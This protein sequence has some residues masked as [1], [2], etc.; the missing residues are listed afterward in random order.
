L[1]ELVLGLA[2]SHSP[3]LTFGAELW[4]ARAADDF[5]NQQ[6]TL[7][8]G[9][10]LSYGDLLAERGGKYEENAKPDRFAECERLAG[11]QL[12]RLA[13]ELEAAAPDLVIIIGDD[14]GELFDPESM[15]AIAVYHGDVV[16][17]HP[18]AKVRPSIP[19]W[20]KA[21]A[22]VFMMDE[23]HHLPGASAYAYRLI[24]RLI[25]E[26]V[27]LAAIGRVSEP[28]RA[29]FGHAY[30]FVVRRLFG[31]RRIPI[32]PVMLNTYF[33]PNVLSAARCFDIGRLM[34]AAIRS[35]P[36]ALRVAVI[37]SG[38]LSHFVTDEKL[39]RGVLGALSKGNGEDLRTLPRAA[40]RSGS[41]EILNWVVAAGA[42]NN[43]PLVW[44][45]YIPVYRTPAGTGIGL[46]FACWRPK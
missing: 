20:R 9:R 29:G 46:G 28:E 24:Q 5:G 1:S 23:A 34:G 42:L 33:P 36:D 8:D 3:L 7:S 6:L 16:V 35:S 10:T 40:L 32:V 43:L 26:G 13:K 31:E 45:E 27:D 41:S 39:D 44:S 11:I 19:A 12:D 4:G 21:A 30:G 37:A 38:G 25:D 14:Q 18:L 17:M 15:P 22:K 2:T